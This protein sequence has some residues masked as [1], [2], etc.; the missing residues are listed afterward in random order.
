M[1]RWDNYDYWGGAL[2]IV[3]IYDH[4]LTSSDVAVNYFGSKGRFGL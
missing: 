3:R 2:A 4:A 1:K